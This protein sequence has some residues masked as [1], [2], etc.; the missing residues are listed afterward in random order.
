MFR[1]RLASVVAFALLAAGSAGHAEEP[2]VKYFVE[3][4]V[5]SIE[6]AKDLADAGFDVAGVN[7]KTAAVG[8]VVTQGELTRL[9]KLGWPVTVRTS[10]AAASATA[11]LA[12]YTDPQELSAFMDQ[13]VAAYPSLAKKI[14]LRDTLFAGQTQYALQITKDVA[15][16]NGRPSFILDAQHHAREVMTP[17]IARDMIDYLTSRYATDAQVQRWVDNINIYVVPSVNPDGGMYVFTNDSLWRKNR[18]PSCAV[19]NNR[20]YPSGWG[21][22]NG[23]TGE[24][25]S[26]TFRGTAA[27]SEPETQG[28]MQLTSDV[29]PLFALSY[30]SYGEYIMYPYGCS[31]PDELSAFDEIGQGLNAIL[32]NDAGATGQYATGPVWRTLYLAD[33]TSIDT[34]YGLYGTYAYVIEVTSSDFAP[35]YATWR[36]VTVQRQRTAWGYFLDKTLDG[37]QI[38]GTVT[39]AGTGQPLAATVGLDEVTLTHGESPRRADAKGHYHL[40]V[41]SGGTYHLSVSLPGYCTVSQEVV[42]GTGPATVDVALIRPTIP[43][44]VIAAAA[45]DNAI[46]VSWQPAANADEYRVLRSLSAG[47]PYSLIATVPGTQLSYHDAP[48]SGVATYS[49]IVRSVQGCESGNSAEAQATTT[50]AC[51]VGPSFAGLSS[52]TNAGSSTCALNLTWPAAA[53]RCG[54]NVTYRVY[55]S[56][57][58]PVV[59]SPGTL[60]A[61]GLSGNSYSDHA[62]L[63][64]GGSYSYLVRAVD[65][66]NGA[67]DGNGVTIAATPTGLDSVATWSDNAGDSGTALLTTS[68]P[69]SVKP[70]GGKTGPKVYSTGSYANN[71]CTAITTPAVTVQS[72][73]SLSFASKY[74]METNYDGG[75]VEVATGPA[76]NVWAKLT[77]NYPDSLLNTGNACGFPSSGPG[78]AFSRTIAAP[79]YAASPYTG[80]LAA[81]AG[82]SVKLRWRF[83]SDSNL[84]R[85]GWWIDDI[86]ITDTLVPGTCSPGTAPNPGEPSGAGT[87]TASR[88][89]SGT[90]VDVTYA[91][92]CGTL[93]NAVY[94]GTGPIAGS[95]AWTHAACAVDNT[96]RASFDPG[97]PAPGSFFYFVVVG[98]SG[99]KEGSYGTGSAGERPE[100]IG[101]GSCD[102]PQDL[103]GN[104]PS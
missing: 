44:G 26:D 88:A 89:S 23:S 96:G 11:A 32:E 56:A 90:G 97:V 57:T 55:R 14:T 8:V 5:P 99:S 49:Y 25:S 66:V 37:A 16:D 80:S 10:N 24:C 73:S 35:S 17:E 18:H 65:A 40:L 61:S 64:D 104:C 81:Y 21:S 67:D 101:V 83:A 36:D 38:R 60:V 12:D 79:S 103:T 68:P 47:G 42:V 19:D 20:N 54:G 91:P 34:Q 45:G 46:D 74:D 39:D 86:V 87:M 63:V 84:T 9:T 58:P 93:D 1:P 82:Q 92:G 100:A 51:S 22:C 62:A 41:H 4:S 48:V 3:V 27:G 31:D 70:S 72:S 69:W 102:R 2:E 6:S 30:H 50:G 85:A 59:P 78:T 15:V 52:V 33:G 53:S 94:W 75:V 7:R 98:Q 76:L 95:V 28:L 77:V 29:R 43:Q 13:V 71:L